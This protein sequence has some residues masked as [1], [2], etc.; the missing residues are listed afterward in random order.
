MNKKDIYKQ[1]SDIGYY[2][3]LDNISLVTWI[4]TFF[5]TILLG[6]E[7]GLFCGFVAVL[8]LNTYRNKAMDAIEVGQVEN[9]EIFTDVNIFDTHR[10]NDL[11]IIRPSQSLLYVNCDIFHKKLNVLCPLKAYTEPADFIDNVH[12]FS[13]FK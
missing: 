4:I 7:I 1:V 11:K 3:K 8:F 2:W 6:T 10:F 13:I 5:S 12:F 9:F